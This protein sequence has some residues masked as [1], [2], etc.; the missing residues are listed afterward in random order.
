MIDSMKLLEYNERKLEEP[1]MTLRDVLQ[2]INKVRISRFA[3]PVEFT[4][5][6]ELKEYLSPTAEV[7]SVDPSG[8][9]SEPGT[10]CI[11][12]ATRDTIQKKSRL[13]LPPAETVCILLRRERKW[14]ARKF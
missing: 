2:N 5:A 11:V 9:K 3:D 1:K 7:L 6:S 12:L 8:M 14:L 4:V 13:R 10:L